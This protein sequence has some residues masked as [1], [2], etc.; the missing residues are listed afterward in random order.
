[1]NEHF[2]REEA[3]KICLSKQHLLRQEFIT[4]KSRIKYVVNFIVPV[5]ANKDEI[6]EFRELVAEYLQTK[7]RTE[8]FKFDARPRADEF[9]PVLF[10]RAD[11]KGGENLLSVPLHSFVDQEGQIMYGFQVHPQSI[12]F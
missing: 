12:L 8:L 1:M 11:L 4:P 3:V 7:D 2:T 9:V 5:P 10:G 6:D